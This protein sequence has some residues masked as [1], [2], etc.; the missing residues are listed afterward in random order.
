MKKRHRKRQ[1]VLTINSIILIFILVLSG[2]SVGYSLLSS[3]LSVVGKGNL[4][5]QGEDEG[6]IR[7]THTSNCWYNEGKFYCNIAGT[8][9][10]LTTMK[11]EGWIVTMDVPSDAEV[12]CWSA[13]CTV[14]DGVLTL[15]NVDYNAILSPNVDVSI[16]FQLSTKIGEWEPT[17]IKVNGQNIPSPSP[18]PS[19][20]P[21]PS[22]TETPEPTT[23][24]TPEPSPEPTDDITVTLT[25]GN[26]WVS[27]ENYMRQYSYTIT[28]NSSTSTNSWRFDMSVPSGTTVFGAWDMNYIENTDTNIITFSNGEWN[29]VIAAGETLTLT[30]QLSSIQEEYTPVISNIS[31]T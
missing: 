10:N 29:G 18:T 22:P 21:S 25:L 23:S 27:G 12:I 4:I 20:T 19:P 13:A 15:T 2:I 8:L 14:S 7:F 28:N 11:I 26:T 31:K 9:T 5:V 3:K 17:N 24:P 6:D 16:G 30:F 1:R